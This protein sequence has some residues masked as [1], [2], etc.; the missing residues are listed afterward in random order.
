MKKIT[1]VIFGTI[2]DTEEETKLFSVLNNIM[3]NRIKNIHWLCEGESYKRSCTSIKDN[4]VHLLT[5]ALFVNMLILDYK[6]GYTYPEFNQMF[7]ERIIELFIT[8][9][10]CDKDIIQFIK[11][12]YH[13]LI[14]FI[15]EN[16]NL[17][18]VYGQLENINMDNLLIN[19]REIILNILTYMKDKNMID[20]HFE[21]CAIDFYKTGITCEDEIL[22][23]MREK[24]FIKLILHKINSLDNS[25]HIIIITV[26]MDHCEP[27]KKILTKFNIKVKIINYD[28]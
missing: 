26:G 22:T 12:P 4:K 16:K 23:L 1:V 5:D 13:N 7:Y 21:Q 25:K 6:K 8:I 2:H 18:Y 10:K 24:S 28:K 20:Q 3:V 11:Q 27:L 17:E 15:K 9:S 14:I 19:M